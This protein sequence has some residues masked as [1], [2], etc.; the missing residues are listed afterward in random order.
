MEVRICTK[1]GYPG[2]V[3]T[4]KQGLAT[5][6]TRARACTTRASDILRYGGRV[7]EPHRNQIF[8]EGRRRGEHQFS[9]GLHRTSQQSVQGYSAQIYVH[10][11]SSKAL[12]PLRR[13]A[14]A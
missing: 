9:P 3:V 11:N 13:A 14:R 12:R 2:D 10:W 5:F 1:V 8:L 4:R 7:L 6:G